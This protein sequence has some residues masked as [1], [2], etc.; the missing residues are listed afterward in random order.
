MTGL[1]ASTRGRASVRSRAAT[2]RG[3]FG[4][5]RGALCLWGA[6]VLGCGTSA[7]DAADTTGARWAEL[8]LALSGG[9]IERGYSGTLALVTVTREQVGLCTAT[10]LAPNLLATAR[11]CVAPTS[12][13]VVRC[14]EDPGTFSRPY[15][16]DSL[17]VNHARTLSGPLQDFGLLPSTG[18]GAEFV[19]VADVFVPE[20]DDVCGGDLA[21]LILSA[22][23]DAAE[24]TP[25]AP[26]LDVAV[27]RGAPYTAIGFGGTP[28]ASGEGT[29]R[30]RTGLA[31]NCTPDDCDSMGAFEATEFQGGDGVCSGDSGGPA[32]DAEGRVVGIASRSEACK[33]SVYSA[34]ASWRDFIRQVATQAARA[35][36]YPAPDWLIAEPQPEPIEPETPVASATPEESA[37]PEPEPPAP[38]TEAASEANDVARRPLV[39]NDAGGGSG[40]STAGA[41]LQSQ[42]PPLLLLL[43]LCLGTLALRHGPRRRRLRLP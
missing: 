27:T 16:A 43:G 39:S 11:H 19:P 41:S 25:L 23:F 38:E 36:D 1:S 3:H 42:R 21:L 2:L 10:L 28:E 40:C 22:D 24:A 37:A 33:N 17:W 18:G 9:Q 15:S 4:S 26:R 35:G 12:A 32:F 14:S 29:R 20:T 30:S 13:D 5:L 34:V 7:P 8:G 6:G 31:V